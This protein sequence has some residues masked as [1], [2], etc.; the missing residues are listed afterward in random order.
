[1]DGVDRPNRLTPAGPCCPPALRCCSV[2]QL[3]NGSGA[4]GRH[5]VRRRRD[6]L[7]I[8][9]SGR[10]SDRTP[11]KAS[12]D[13]AVVKQARRPPGSANAL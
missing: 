7:T 8:A 5:D 10:Q 3:M 11:T 4:T 2:S 1:M 12:G 6:A 9:S 13:V